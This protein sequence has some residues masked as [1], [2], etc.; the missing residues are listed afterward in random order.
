MNKKYLIIITLVIVSSFMFFSCTTATL[1]ERNKTVSVNGSAVLSITPDSASMR[2]RVSEIGVNTKEAQQ[3]VNVKIASIL[4]V[5]N[6]VGVSK[7]DISTTGYEFSPE[8]EYVEN[9]RELVG[10]R[11]SQSI[12]FVVREINTKETLLATILDR[13]ADISNISLGSITFSKEDMSGLYDE[14]RTLAMLDAINKGSLYARVANL[15]L[16]DPLIISDYSNE[17]VPISSRNEG[18]MVKASAM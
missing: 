18:M 7:D 6:E 8:Y 12:Y 9:K 10:Q 15:S 1:V 3:Q 13:L 5:L 14:V 2:I 4:S 17:A 11:V 16:G